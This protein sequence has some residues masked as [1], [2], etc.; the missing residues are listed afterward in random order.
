ME[1]YYKFWSEC[2]GSESIHILYSPPI[3]YVPCFHISITNI[4]KNIVYWYINI[5]IYQYYYITLFRLCNNFYIIGNY[6]IFWQNSSFGEFERIWLFWLFSYFSCLIPTWCT[7]ALIPASYSTLVL[8]FYLKQ[9]ARVLE[10]ICWWNRRRNWSKEA[11]KS[12][13]NSA[14]SYFFFLIIFHTSTSFNMKI[15]K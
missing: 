15:H 14:L 5:S 12:K 9:T 2:S 10:C 6:D 4:R 3:L 11:M 13:A 1:T 7:F 8:S